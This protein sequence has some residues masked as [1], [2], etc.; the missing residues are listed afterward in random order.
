MFIFSNL[1][2]RDFY[3]YRW[4]KRRTFK[5]RFSK[6]GRLIDTMQPPESESYH[7]SGETS[8]QTETKPK[9]EESSIG[10]M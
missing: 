6:W 9:S 7:Y 1:F 4:F 10:E 2:L 8:S 5:N 3:E